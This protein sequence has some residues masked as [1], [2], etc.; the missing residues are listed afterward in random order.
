MP[1]TDDAHRLDRE[2]IE[3]FNEL[4]VLIPGV[5]VLFAFFLTV[6]FNER[7]AGIDSVQRAAFYVAFCATAASSAF[8][9]APSVLHRL[10]WRQHDKDRLLRYSNRLAIIG[11]G[12]LAISVT[13]VVWLL[14]DYV[15]GGLPAV[16][17]TGVISLLILAIWF[18]LALRM[19][20][21]DRKSVV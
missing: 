6:P 21:S 20:A 12:F 2:L 16:L 19:E 10:R 9:I 11:A 15:Y 3:L 1:D 4:R 14:T 18:G 13:V 17:A 5:Q 8:L 7:F